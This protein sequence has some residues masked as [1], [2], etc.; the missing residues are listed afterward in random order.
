MKKIF[1]IIISTAAVYCLSIAAS[2]EDYDDESHMFDEPPISHYLVGSDLDPHPELGSYGYFIDDGYDLVYDMFDIAEFHNTRCWSG[3]KVKDGT[4]ELCFNGSH[5]D[6]TMG[7]FSCAKLTVRIPNTVNG[8]TV[9]KFYGSAECA[10]F[11]VDPENQYFK[12]DGQ[13]VFSKDGKILL[14]YIQCN[15]S[16]EYVVPDGTEIIGDDAFFKCGNLRKV[17]IPGSV[18]EIE[19]SAFWLTDMEMFVFED[20]NIS[21]NQA[22]FPYYWILKE[23]AAL[24]KA[25]LVC[26]KTVKPT[27]NGN[28][29][30]WN[31]VDGAS[32]YEIYQ[33]LQN[34]EYKLLGKTKKTSHTFG[35]LKQGS[36]YTL[37]VKPAAVIPAA[38]C[39]RQYAGK[40]Y[41]ETFTIEGTMSEDILIKI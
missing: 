34:D 33:K 7:K 26:T 35:S 5:V 4:V 8:M 29:I 38:H 1:L 36:E 30:G 27:A 3:S 31:A 22:A 41:P 24:P 23:E 32:Y 28:T 16:T 19:D 2:A 40:K 18:K 10:A 17:Y 11:D 12:S 25:E 15:E 14:S 6:P 20:F 39:D 21:I 37:A 13:T 9:S